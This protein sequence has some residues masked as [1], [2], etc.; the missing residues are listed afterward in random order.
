MDGAVR[1]GGVSVEAAS[2]FVERVIFVTKSFIGV[3]SVLVS[4]SGFW[5]IKVPVCCS[6]CGGGIRACWTGG[7]IGWPCWQAFM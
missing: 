2:C 3:E 5:F 6:L 7:N 4:S 1:F